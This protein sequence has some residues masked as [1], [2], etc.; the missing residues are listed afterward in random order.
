MAFCD[1]C[2]GRS[3]T[4]GRGRANVHERGCPNDGARWDTNEGVWIK[5]AKCFECGDVIDCDNRGRY[6]CHCFD[7][8]EAGDYANEE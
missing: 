3:V 7:T 2:D 4:M 5:Q 1:Q 6:E 8:S